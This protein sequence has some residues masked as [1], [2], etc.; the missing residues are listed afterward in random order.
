M[1]VQQNF[2]ACKSCKCV[3]VYKTGINA[4][5]TNTIN[6]HVCD[7]MVPDAG[8]GQ[9]DAIDG[10]FLRDRHAVFEAVAGK[11]LKAVI[12]D[13]LDI[14]VASSARIDVD[15]LLAHPVSIRRNAESRTASGRAALTVV[16]KQHLENGV[17]VSC[18]LDLWT[19]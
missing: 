16:L 1:G 18:T 17:G 11:G 12:Q 6:K 10:Q 13:A 3:Y 8:K 7:N 15:D 2:A 14:G 19:D 5:G 4:T 9:D